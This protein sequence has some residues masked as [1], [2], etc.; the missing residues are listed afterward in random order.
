M[1]NSAPSARQ[2]ERFSSVALA[3]ITAF[4]KSGWLPI[5]DM[6]ELDAVQHRHVDI[7]DDEIHFAA[8]QKFN[9]LIGGGR[10]MDL[11]DFHTQRGKEIPN[12]GQKIRVVVHEQDLVLFC[13]CVHFLS[14]NPHLSAAIPVPEPALP[15]HKITTGSGVSK[16]FNSMPPRRSGPPVAHK[17][18]RPG[19]RW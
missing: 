19:W 14:G 2:A 9:C 8:F 5:E 16:A 7:R 15:G 13:R 17:G 12:H 10:A 11:P 3:V 6:E 18:R 4:F 1:N